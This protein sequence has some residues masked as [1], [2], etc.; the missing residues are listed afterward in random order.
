MKKTI[1]ACSI[2]VALACAVLLSNRKIR[3]SR[4]ELMGRQMAA[5]LEKDPENLPRSGW[6]DEFRQTNLG[7]LDC[8]GRTV[9]EVIGMVNKQ[10]AE[11][12]PQGPKLCIMMGIEEDEGEVVSRDLPEATVDQRITDLLAFVPK[13]T[14]GDVMA[15]S[16]SI[17]WR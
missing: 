11:A 3:E 14:K 7:Q 6:P 4:A 2:L 9:T 13:P 16:Y 12:F 5:V 17:H 15:I 10:I 8:R 1:A